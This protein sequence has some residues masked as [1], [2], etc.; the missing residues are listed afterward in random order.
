MSKTSLPRFL[1]TLAAEQQS[2]GSGYGSSVPGSSSAGFP[3]FGLGGSFPAGP[4]PGA[5]GQGGRGRNDLRMPMPTDAEAFSMTSYNANYIDGI[6]IWRIRSNGDLEC[7]KPGQP[8]FDIMAAAIMLGFD[9]MESKPWRKR[10]KQHANTMFA[11]IQDIKRLPLPPGRI[12]SDDAIK[13]YS[14]DFIRRCRQ[15]SPVAILHDLGNSQWARTLKADWSGRGYFNAQMAATVEYNIQVMS[16]IP[17]LFAKL[18]TST[19]PCCLVR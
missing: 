18:F 12:R 3:Q 17:I 9:I 15:N 2:R 4:G 1:Y 19:K 5:P 10:M 7:L 14:E 11:Y 6:Q 16:I 8:R 13:N